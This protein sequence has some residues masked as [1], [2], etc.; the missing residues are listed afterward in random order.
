MIEVFKE[1][2]IPSAACAEKLCFSVPWSAESLKM[3]THEPFFGLVAT[4]DGKFAAYG[5]MMCV[6]DE[7][8]MLNVATLPEYRRRGLA[9]EILAGL[10]DEARAR[11]AVT[12]TL[13]VRESNT[14]A[15]ELYRNEGLYEIGMRPNYYQDP[16]EAAIL[17][18][19]QL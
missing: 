7:A 12:M 13:E 8:Q 15:R 2:H 9:R 14:A 10:Y 5:G 11:G 6:L 17:M 19:K 1:E 16:R 4:V 18:E 3:L